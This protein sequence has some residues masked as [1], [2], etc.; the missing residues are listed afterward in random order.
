MGEGEFSRGEDAM[1]GEGGA[2]CGDG[3]AMCGEG[4][5]MCGEELCDESGDWPPM[6]PE[7][8]NWG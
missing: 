8:P 7:P 1:C 6:L 3:G 2:M 5:A 4:G